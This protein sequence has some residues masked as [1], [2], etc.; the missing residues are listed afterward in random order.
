MVN[1]YVRYGASPRGGQ[2]LVLGGKVRA[3]L[4]GR[5]GVAFDDIAEVAKDALRHRIIPNFEAEAEGISTDEII[6]DL[7]KA[8]PREAVVTA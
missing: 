2:A 3:L 4:D 7:L 8:L 1:Q 5:S 6:D